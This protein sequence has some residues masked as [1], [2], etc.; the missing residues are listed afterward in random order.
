[1]LGLAVIVFAG[2]LMYSGAFPVFRKYPLN[3][4]GNGFTV[5]EFALLSTEK[6]KLYRK[7]RSSFETM[8]NVYFSDDED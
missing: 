3:K 1:M 4:R 7:S 8:S 5:L 6:P 2:H